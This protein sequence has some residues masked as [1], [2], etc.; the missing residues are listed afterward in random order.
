MSARSS[1]RL[2]HG[3]RLDLDPPP[4][5]SASSD[6][7]DDPAETSDGR[8]K[9][10]SKKERLEKMMSP[11]KKTPHIFRQLGNKREKDAGVDVLER[12]PAQE[13]LSRECGLEGN[14]RVVWLTRHGSVDVVICVGL[15]RFSLV[16]MC[17][18]SL[19]RFSDMCGLWL[20]VSLS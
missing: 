2:R 15:A 10:D 20:M 9:K 1:G 8:A 11:L 4:S 14:G 16:L 19:L 3:D 7:L 12:E 18:V 17:C 5:P 6:P 13:D